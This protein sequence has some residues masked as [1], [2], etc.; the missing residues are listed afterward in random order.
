[1]AK[2]GPWSGP[3]GLFRLVS[4]AVDVLSGGD[5]QSLIRLKF[6]F[7]DNILKSESGYRPTDVRWTC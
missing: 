1:M 3:D 2:S 7:S 6:L 4:E 5:N